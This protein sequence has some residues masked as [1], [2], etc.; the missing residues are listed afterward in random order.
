MRGHL[1]SPS[2]SP[3]PQRGEE[4]CP[5]PAPVPQDQSTH[6]FSVIPDSS[7]RKKKQGC[8]SALGD[9]PRLLTRTLPLQEYPSSSIEWPK[10]RLLPPNAAGVRTSP[11][12]CSE[13]LENA[14]SPTVFI[15]DF[16]GF[17]SLPKLN[18]GPQTSDSRL[19]TPDKM[20]LS[21][22][23]HFLPGY[24]LLFFISRIPSLLQEGSGLFHELRPHSRFIQ[25]V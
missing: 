3:A 22:T 14:L 8:P 13:T 5:S 12:R 24:R 2:P 1:L 19:R 18:Q 9:R 23:V 15:D 4:A 6:C 7:T 10:S 20:P 11:R 17:I 25:T 21:H 16:T